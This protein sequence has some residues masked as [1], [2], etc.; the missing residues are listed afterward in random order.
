MARAKPRRRRHD[1]TQPAD[2]GLR[3]DDYAPFTA[4]DADTGRLTTA[5]RRRDRIADM[6]RADRIDR[7]QLLAL[8]A[9][10]N[11]LE[12]AGYGNTRSCINFARTSGDGSPTIAAVSARVAFLTIIDASIPHDTR[13]TLEQVALHNRTL[14]EVAADRC[15]HTNAALYVM[16]RRR[17]ASAVAIARE[18]AWLRTAADCLAVVMRIGA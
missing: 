7:R 15:L 14:E 16:G 18:L 17:R 4:T 9:Y 5:Y 13:Y 1:I 2:M 8:E 11:A 12:A 10:R 6:H 3:P